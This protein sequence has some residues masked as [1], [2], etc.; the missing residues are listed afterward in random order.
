MYTIEGWQNINVKDK[1]PPHP[2]FQIIKITDDQV[3]AGK[4]PFK[5]ESI[6]KGEYS[7]VA[8][9]DKNKDGK[10][11]RLLGGQIAEPRGLYV[12]PLTWASWQEISFK[13]DQDTTDVD[14]AITDSVYQKNQ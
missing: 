2:Y 13:L 7:I 10:L 8:Y 4:I 12:E 5:F 14:I 3:K 9:Q 11:D 6:Q 1:F